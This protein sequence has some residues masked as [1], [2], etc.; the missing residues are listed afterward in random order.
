MPL[1]NGS[2]SGNTTTGSYV[3]TASNP[4]VVSPDNSTQLLRIVAGLA[5]IDNCVLVPPGL[6]GF[7]G[8]FATLLAN[9]SIQLYTGGMCD[10]GTEMG[11]ALAIPAA[12]TAGGATSS[13]SPSPAAHRRMLLSTANSSAAV[14]PLQRLQAPAD[15][16][17]GGHVAFSLRLYAPPSSAG[18]AGDT[19]VR[20]AIV[21]VAEPATA[22]TG[23]AADSSRRGVGCVRS[24]PHRSSW[25]PHTARRRQP[26]ACAA[27]GGN[28]PAIPTIRLSSVRRLGVYVLNLGSLSPAITRIDLL[29]LPEA[30]AAS[31]ANASLAP[32][33]PGSAAGAAGAQQGLLPVA[34]P[35]YTGISG[36]KA[37]Q[38]PALNWFVVK[39]KAVARAAAKAATALGGT[40]RRSGGAQAWV[41]A[42]ARL[43]VNNAPVAG[44]PELPNIHALGL[45]LERAV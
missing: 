19:S 1:T 30:E 17:S 25:N 35:V 33:R 43:S 38:C 2:S 8:Y 6:V 23:A 45:E 37:L 27:S 24:R 29:L 13:P 10:S 39:P 20:N 36:G 14:V 22:A 11:G 12:A 7:S 42:G 9:A 28:G 32:A 4:D 5:G 16:F 40:N 21:A 44:R 15:V 41:V 34:V 26:L 18:T 3:V 31:A